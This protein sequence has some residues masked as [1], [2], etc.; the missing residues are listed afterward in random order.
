MRSRPTQV[1][2]KGRSSPIEDA[3]P[4]SDEG[5][6]DTW[7]AE[8]NEREEGGGGDTWVAEDKGREEGGGGDTW[9]AED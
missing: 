8:D 2:A 5:G 6:G 4:L 1:G 3:R 7:V 9:V